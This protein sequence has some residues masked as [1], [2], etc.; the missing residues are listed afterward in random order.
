MDKYQKAIEIAKER[1]PMV[2]ELYFMNIASHEHFIAVGDLD[3]FKAVGMLEEVRNI[4]V[5]ENL[6][7]AFIV[8][9]HMPEIE[10]SAKK[11]SHMFWKRR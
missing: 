6:G 11:M 1:F 9:G 2:K 3:I 8:K 7:G 4:Q 10:S 5:E